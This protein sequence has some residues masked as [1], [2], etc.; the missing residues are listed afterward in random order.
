MSLT[1]GNQICNL[2]S[3]FGRT[4]KHITGHMGENKWQQALKFEFQSRIQNL[5]PLAK[6]KTD[7]IEGKRLPVFWNLI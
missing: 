2:N 4:N 1:S 7:C 6:A 5:K 3:N